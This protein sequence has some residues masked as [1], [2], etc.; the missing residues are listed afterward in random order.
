MLKY[1]YVRNPSTQRYLA[2][3]TTTTTG[4][5]TWSLSVDSAILFEVRS[6]TP[7]FP[8]EPATSLG[9]QSGVTAQQIIVP[10][11]ADSISSDVTI[12]TVLP[13]SGR[14]LR[15]S[16]DRRDTE[17]GYRLS[18]DAM[19]FGLAG[20][21]ESVDQ[22]EHYQ[23][24]ILSTTLQGTRIAAYQAQITYFVDEK[25]TI[26][27][28]FL[29]LPNS[30]T[31]E[32]V[33]PGIRMTP[34]FTTQTWKSLARY[35]PQGVGE[36]QTL[37]TGLLSRTDELQVIMFESGDCTG[38]QKMLP[39]GLHR[40]I[41]GLQSPQTI[42][43]PENA[44]AEFFAE[45]D[46]PVG[47]VSTVYDP[48]IHIVSAGTR[49]Q[50][51]HISR[52]LPVDLFRASM[53]DGFARDQTRS[54]AFLPQSEAADDSVQRLCRENGN[55][56]SACNCIREQEQLRT[57]FEELG[58]GELINNLPVKCFGADCFSEGYLLRDMEQ[59]T[60][61]STI[62]VQVQRQIGSEITSLGNQQNLVC[63]GEDFLVDGKLVNELPPTTE[64][65]P[66]TT[67]RVGVST[68]AAIGI[69]LGA[70][71]LVVLGMFAVWLV[72]RRVRQ[73]ESTA[74]K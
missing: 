1:V 34:D 71:I 8:P 7:V 36:C 4:T 50:S 66:T 51:A 43:V 25:E 48:G 17:V 57:T 33:Q 72:D 11:P 62:C 69:A 58:L 44:R 30:G 29:D 24:R 45:L 31:V 47:G 35:N 74:T 53:A 19:L 52:I 68:N 70:V 18:A 2:E 61:N 3:V 28:N 26:L 73:K 9:R 23:L 32:L 63:N 55:Q 64:V 67:V 6:T 13:Q 16:A 54:T 15:F 56:I 21:E 22:R 46:T 5:L 10:A 40:A 41:V 65:P 59:K 20:E 42:F 27:R 60:C 37:V 49:Y 14:W 12:Q 39:F 38:I